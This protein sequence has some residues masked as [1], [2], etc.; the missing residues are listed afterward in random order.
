MQA[1]PDLLRPALV[2]T[3]MVLLSAVCIAGTIEGELPAATQPPPHHGAHPLLSQAPEADAAQQGKQ[4]FESHCMTCHALPNP[5]AYP[6]AK[7]PGI[8]D[9][10]A[11]RASLNAEQRQLLMEYLESRHKQAEQP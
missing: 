5:T 7:W 11:P 4:L 2:A 10:M 8:L 9:R 3:L 6:L 1:R